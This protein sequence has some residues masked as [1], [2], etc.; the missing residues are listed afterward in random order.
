MITLLDADEANKSG[1]TFSFIGKDSQFQ[2][3][4]WEVTYNGEFW[5][6][7]VSKDDG[8]SLSGY[9][10]ENFYFHVEE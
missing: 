9:F 2:N 10:D 4:I 1:E 5:E 8:F 7:E 6:V 3:I